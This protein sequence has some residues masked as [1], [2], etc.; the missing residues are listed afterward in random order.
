VILFRPPKQDA[1]IDWIFLIVIGALLG[2]I[3]KTFLLSAVL[4]SILEPMGWASQPKEKS[5]EK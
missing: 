2:N 4:G 3:P 1:T 5:K